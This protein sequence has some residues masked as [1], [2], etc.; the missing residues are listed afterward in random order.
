MKKEEI[1]AVLERVR[2][3]PKARQ[4]DVEEAR[5]GKTAGIA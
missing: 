1:I 5:Y 2:T 4:E 3:W